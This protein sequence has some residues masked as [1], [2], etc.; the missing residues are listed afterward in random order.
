MMKYF[1]VSGIDS[2]YEAAYDGMV[3]MAQ[4]AYQTQEDP[5]TTLQK[6][7]NG[8]NASLAKFKGILASEYLTIFEDK[9]DIR[10]LIKFYKSSTGVQYKKDRSGLTKGQLA[11]LE[12]FKTSNKGMKLFGIITQI[13]KL[14]ESASIYW[15]K[16]LICSVTTKLKEQGFQSSMHMPSCN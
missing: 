6:I 3:K 14:K 15:S 16:E 5:A 4:D 8:K 1:E 2:E 11:E 9:K 10:N 7:H 13:N 12:E